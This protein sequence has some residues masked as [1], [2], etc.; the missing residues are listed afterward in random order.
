MDGC[1]DIG[2]L[3]RI[4]LPLSGP[5]IAV[6]GL[7]Y[8]VNH[9]NQFFNGLIYLN[10]RDLFPLQLVLRNILL[11][12]QQLSMDTTGMTTEEIDS[13]TKQAY[14]AEVMKYALIFIAS[15]PVLVAYPFIQRF[16]VKG[17]MIGSI[18]G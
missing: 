13:L 18:K 11:L 15:F 8:G 5:I 1:S 3:W 17:V 2:M 12:N 16:F 7:F 4:A 14:M 6:M 9:W 10:D